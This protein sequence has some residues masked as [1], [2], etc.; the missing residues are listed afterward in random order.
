MPP[1]ATVFMVEDDE[2]W[3][4]INRSNLERAGHK[5]VAEATTR[6]EA[7]EQVGKLGELGVN[8]AVIDGNL[9]TLDGVFGGD[10]QAVLA[11]IRQLAPGV[12]V[13]GMAGDTIRGAD[14]NVGKRHAEKL[15]NAV[16]EL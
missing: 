4:D 7:L 5:V 10:G 1:E 13:V 9:D 16:T 11:A 3:R 8:V 15:A 14:I 6:A 2:Q 12:K